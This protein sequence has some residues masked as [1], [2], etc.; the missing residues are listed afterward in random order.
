MEPGE[1]IETRWATFEDKCGDIVDDMR[2]LIEAL[3]KA[4]TESAEEKD[5]SE[6]VV[7]PLRTDETKA[8][9]AEK[10]GERIE[11]M[12]TGTLLALAAIMMGGRHGIGVLT[13]HRLRERRS[14]RMAF[15]RYG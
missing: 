7:A 11:H 12:L 14:F 9:K 10:D 6:D 4:A 8:D 1:G 13:R 5:E 2:T 3:D 15:G